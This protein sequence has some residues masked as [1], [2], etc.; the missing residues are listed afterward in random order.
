MKALRSAIVLLGICSIGLGCATPGAPGPPDPDPWERVNRKIFAFNET[1]DEYALEPAA[2]AWDFV[3]PEI[4]QTG[5]SNFFENLRLPTVFVNDLLQGKPEAAA[6]DVVRLLSNSVFGLGGFIDVATAFKIPESDED[7][8]QTLGVWGV[9]SG[10]Y[11]MV[12]LL[13][14]YTVRSGAGQV[15]EAAATSYAYFSPFWFDVANLNGVETF[16]ASVGM[17]ALELLNLRAIY[18]E[19]LEASR[20]DA[21]DYYVFI[22]NAYLQSRRAKVF[23]HK[24]RPSR[25]E[26]DLYYFEEEFDEDLDGEISDEDEEDFDDY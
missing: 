6:F 2:T 1:V 3:V 4:A 7:F 25:A 5:L 20:N 23:D 10:P 11:L 12:P 26:D 17:R 13:G 21:F 22:R 9:P 16:G 18:L 24:D 8:G 19:E 14:P 15:I